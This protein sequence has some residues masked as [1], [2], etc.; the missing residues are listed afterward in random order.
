[1]WN[2]VRFSRCPL[3]LYPVR[4]TSLG[5][6][7][8]V[9]VLEI[10]NPL[11]VLN[12]GTGVRGDKEFDGLGHAVLRHEGSRLRSSK[13]GSSSSLVAGAGTGRDSQETARDVLFL[14]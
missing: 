6:V 3:T 1:M 8:N 14:G 13:L 10:K 2:S 5:N 4:L 7:G 12:D 11:G 9:V